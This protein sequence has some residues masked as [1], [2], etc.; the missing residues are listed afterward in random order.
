VR[1]RGENPRETRS[2]WVAKDCND[3]LSE[4]ALVL[5]FSALAEKNSLEFKGTH[6]YGWYGSEILL[7]ESCLEEK[8]L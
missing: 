4:I 8:M 1:R 3:E 6:R 7:M 5:G 2:R